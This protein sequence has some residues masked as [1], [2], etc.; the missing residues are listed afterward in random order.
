MFSFKDIPRTFPDNLNYKEESGPDS[1]R[2]S[3]RR[4]L[5]AHA[6]HNPKIGYCQ[7]CL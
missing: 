1:L 4:V 2:P 5:C 6:V 3:L 7:V